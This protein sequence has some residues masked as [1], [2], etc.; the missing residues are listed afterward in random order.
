MA[1]STV[2]SPALHPL[3]RSLGHGS[4]PGILGLSTLVW[5]AGR[6]PAQA[7]V[8]FLDMWYIWT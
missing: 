3:T 2:L 5:L 8:V 1:L 4:D 7:E 6:G